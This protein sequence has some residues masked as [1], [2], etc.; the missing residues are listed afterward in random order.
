MKRTP[1]KKLVAI[2]GGTG[3]SMLL[4]GLKRYV[5]AAEYGGE[6]IDSLSAVVTVSD[7]GGSSGRL[8]EEF[9]I[10]PPGDIRNCLVALSEDE[11]LMSS[12]FRHRFRGSGELGNH[13]FGNLYLTAL[14]EITG[15]FLEAIRH[16]S[17]ILKTK[18]R[19]FP[20]TMSDVVLVAELADGTIV[21][22]ESKISKST[23]PIVR[24]GLDPAEVFP[25]PETLAAI[26]EASII[27]L[28]PG[29][30]FTSIIPN[31]LVNGIAE[32]ITRSKALKV[33]ICNV[34]TQPG[35]TT[36]FSIID[37]IEKLFQHAPSLEVDVVLVNSTPISPPMIEK[38][39]LDGAAPVA[40][41]DGECEIEAERFSSELA[42]RTGRSCRLCACDLLEESDFVRHDPRK[43]SQALL[44]LLLPPAS[45]S[46]SGLENLES[47][48]E[49]QPL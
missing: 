10:L 28:G 47:L 29:S 15:D 8:R 13:S 33:C 21:R 18:G 5:G 35:E 30:L 23:S 9:Q 16:S 1:G 22:G 27:T 48:V 12:L 37:H 43:V 7:D 14:T 41:A 19:I 25:L 11:H 31:L 32:A 42:R 44:S 38:Y 39:R 20:A 34:M 24:V 17:E 6:C 45:F 2:G 49:E 36:G 26:A 46:E 3:L 40:S 4:S